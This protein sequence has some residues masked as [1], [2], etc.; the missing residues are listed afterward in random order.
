MSSKGT[1]PAKGQNHSGVVTD[2]RDSPECKQKMC[3]MVPRISLTEQGQDS[4]DTDEMVANNVQF[5][6]YEKTTGRDNM[7]F[8]K[9]AGL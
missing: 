6:K 1:D 5:P 3:H 8:L 2:I 7:A 4:G 9:E